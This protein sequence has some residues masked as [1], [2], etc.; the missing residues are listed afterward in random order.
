MCDASCLSFIARVRDN[1]RDI[2][3]AEAPPK[4]ASRATMARVV[5]L[6][7]CASVCGR[8]SN[9][10]RAV[11]LLAGSGGSA[12]RPQ[13]KEPHGGA[14]S[15]PPRALQDRAAPPCLFILGWAD[16]VLRSH[17]VIVSSD[18]RMKP[19]HARRVHRPLMSVL[20]TKV[21]G[22]LRV[23]ATKTKKTSS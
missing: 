19:S 20:A 22:G 9:S 5:L 23:K 1:T 6:W 7:T 21:S 12:A 2:G 10:S 11:R 17:P 8:L 18:T 4:P 14:A 15:P 13:L 16:P 3:C